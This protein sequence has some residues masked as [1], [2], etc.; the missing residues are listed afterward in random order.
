MPPWINP[1]ALYP[2]SGNKD[3]PVSPEDHDRED[4]CRQKVP[5]RTWLSLPS[6]ATDNHQDLSLPHKVSQE[7][8]KKPLQAR[9]GVSSGPEALR[10][11]LYRPG[12]RQDH[13]NSHLHL[14]YL[15]P[16]NPLADGH[17][18]SPYSETRDHLIYLHRREIH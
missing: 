6:S 3:H 8:H 15:S 10:M 16:E 9:Q 2:R 5:F 13:Y 1:L 4:T 14:L 17:L 11:L 7:R 18:I 12:C